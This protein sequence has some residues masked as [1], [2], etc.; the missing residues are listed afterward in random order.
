MHWSIS[1]GCTEHSAVRGTFSHVMEK[2]QRKSN[3]K[4]IFQKNAQKCV[5]MTKTIFG[6]V[7]KALGICRLW[8]QRR[9]LFSREAH[10]EQVNLIKVGRFW[11]FL[12]NSQQHATG[13][14]HCIDNSSLL[15]RYSRLC[16]N[17]RTCSD[18]S[19]Y[20]I[21]THFCVV[22]FFLFFLFSIIWRKVPRFPFKVLEIVSI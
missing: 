1:A 9:D 17:L 6:K 14:S 21:F 5:K 8:R 13:A 16:K 22:V 15:W 12:R 7:R 11:W 18:F 20:V 4:L 2:D 3:L 19:I 10:T